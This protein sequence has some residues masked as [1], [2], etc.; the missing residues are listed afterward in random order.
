MTSSLDTI[1]PTATIATSA[2][3]SEAAVEVP[4]SESATTHTGPALKPAKTS[5]SNANLNKLTGPIKSIVEDAMSPI[6]LL[7]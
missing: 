4:T 1:A 5:A 2:T 3:T 7:P 6:K